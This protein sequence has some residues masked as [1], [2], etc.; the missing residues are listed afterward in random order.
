ML[1]GGTPEGEKEE[2]MT[3][4]ID[5]V[6]ASRF[7]GKFD[8]PAGGCWIW[9]AGRNRDG[10]GCFCIGNSRNRLAHRLSYEF[11]IGPIP[12]G[13]CL[14]HLCRNRGCVNPEHLE[15]VTHL[16]NMRRSPLDFGVYWRSKTHCSQGHPFD[17]ENT[18]YSR[19]HP[20]RR[21]CKACKRERSL[22]SYHSRRRVASTRAKDDQ[23][24]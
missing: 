19:S 2:E 4:I 15:P 22:R 11:F 9:T 7:L 12:D 10:Y 1:C 20:S 13:L 14:D 21:Y 24:E 3:Q 18:G 23:S 17:D 6:R 8:R 5:E 16:E